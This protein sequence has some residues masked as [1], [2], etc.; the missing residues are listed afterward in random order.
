MMALCVH[1]LNRDTGHAISPSETKVR[2]LGVCCYFPSVLLRE[3]VDGGEIG[4]VGCHSI[5]HEW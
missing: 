2:L 3:L 1:L 4:L 5:R